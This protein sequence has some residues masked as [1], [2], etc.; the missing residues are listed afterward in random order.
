MARS[1]LFPFMVFALWLGVLVA[2]CV[3]VT[4]PVAVGSKNDPALLALGQGHA[5]AFV[6]PPQLSFMSVDKERPL[7]SDAYG[8]NEA[9]ALMM[10]TAASYLSEV[11]LQL[12]GVET[13]APDQQEGVASASKKVSDD[14]RLVMSTYRDKSA[15][16][17]VLKQ[18]KD[19]SGAGL[20][21]LQT[22]KVEVGESGMYDPFSGA[23]S[24]G[25]S[26]S[27][28]KAMLV[29]LDDGQILWSSESVARNLPSGG[30]FREAV[31]MLY[32]N[33]PKGLTLA[34]S[35]HD[36]VPDVIDREPNTRPNAEVDYF[37]RSRDDDGDGV[38]NGIDRHFTEPNRMVDEWGVPLDADRDGIDDDKDRCPDTPSGT[39]VD[40][41]G[42]PVLAEIER[43]FFANESAELLP[44]SFTS[45]DSMGEVLSSQPYLILAVNG[46]CDDRGSDDYNQRLSVARA[47]SVVKYLTEKFSAINKDRISARGFGKTQPRVVGT[48][49]VARGQN[50]R[51]E[52]V[53]IRPEDMNK[54]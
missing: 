15:I 16:L 6:L 49:D 52:F 34:D 32:P 22:L 13:A 40:P 29:S 21:F 31:G 48:D 14:A 44:E 27:S 36:G 37:G 51:V 10:A 35:D 19:A 3:M 20:L 33:L 17:P 8:G 12:V 42:C 30:R 43:I 28:L 39:P 25:T 50:R 54:Q 5:K 46:H 53:V 18:I 4:H 1:R 7:P 11:G 23:M 41:R 26:S 9:G 47:E 45:L 38:P 24:Q 2:G